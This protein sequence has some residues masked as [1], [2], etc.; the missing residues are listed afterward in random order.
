MESNAWGR[1]LTAAMILSGP[2][3]QVKGL[4]LSV[5]LGNVAVDRRLEV[6]DE[7]KDTALEATLRQF[8]EEALDGVEP[9]ARGRREVEG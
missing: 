3:V 5:V 1:R 6:D 9:R 8:G 2:A 7:M 4:G